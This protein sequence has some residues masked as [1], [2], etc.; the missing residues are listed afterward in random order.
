MVTGA[1]GG[2][3]S[4]AVALL[5]KLGYQVVAVTGKPEFSELLQKLGAQRIIGRTEVDD[6]SEK[7]LLPSQWSA[8]VDT[9]GVIP[10]RPCCDRQ[11]IGVAWRPAD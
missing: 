8:A 5:A 7:Q 2:V 3:G 4:I 1:T 6:E 11:P 10:W 9:V